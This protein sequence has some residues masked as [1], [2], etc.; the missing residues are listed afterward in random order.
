M[1]TQVDTTKEKTKAINQQKSGK[2]LSK[3][4]H[5][6]KMTFDNNK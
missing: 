3:R 2:D 4:T 5:G 1:E 6:Y